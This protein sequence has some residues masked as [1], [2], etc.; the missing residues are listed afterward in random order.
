[1]RVVNGEWAYQRL[2]RARR[3]GWYCFNI[4]PKRLQ[5]IVGHIPIAEPGHHLVQG[6]AGRIDAGANRVDEIRF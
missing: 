3:F 1:M 2:A 5:I 6:F 4:L